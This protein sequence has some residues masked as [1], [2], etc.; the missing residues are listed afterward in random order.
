M[1]K[2]KA[3]QV[4]ANAKDSATHPQR[5]IQMRQRGTFPSRRPFA[6][7]TQAIAVSN[8]GV[9]TTIRKATSCTAM[10]N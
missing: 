8:I 2:K 6:S 7:P 3:I 5:D 4:I 1:G 9:A 10:G